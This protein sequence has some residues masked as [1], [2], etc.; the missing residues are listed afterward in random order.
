VNLAALKGKMRGRALVDL[1]NIYRP[2]LA[3]EAGLTYVSV[4]RPEKLPNGEGG[5]GSFLT[6]PGANEDTILPPQ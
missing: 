3:H 6:V 5:H 2:E 4:G 1:R